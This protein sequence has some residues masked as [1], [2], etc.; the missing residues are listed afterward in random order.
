MPSCV[1]RPFLSLT[2]ET[3]MKHL[4]LTEDD[5]AFLLELLDWWCEALPDT[6]AATIEDSSIETPEELLTLTE[7]IDE[8]QRRA[9]R[10]RARLRDASPV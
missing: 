4:P 1:Y 7:G 3:D 5:E 2:K 9:D 10:I 8:Q 6:K